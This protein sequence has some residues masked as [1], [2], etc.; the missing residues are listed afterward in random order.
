VE[1]GT[2]A[3][4]ESRK[5]LYNILA[6]RPETVARFLVPR[7]LA[8]RKNGAHIEWLTSRKAMFRFMTSGLARRKLL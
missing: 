3:E 8:A 6:D 4:R 2:P 7:I 1:E 5:R